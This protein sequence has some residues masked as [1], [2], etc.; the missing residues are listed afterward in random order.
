MSYSLNAKPKRGSRKSML[1]ESEKIRHAEELLK[2]VDSLALLLDEVRKRSQR[3]QAAADA[4]GDQVFDLRPT[5]PFAVN[6]DGRTDRETPMGPKLVA[7][8]RGERPFPV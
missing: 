2:E 8:P 5:K 4:I 6:L 7:R 1:S 3:I